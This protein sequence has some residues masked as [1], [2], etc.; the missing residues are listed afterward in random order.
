MMVK[1]KHKA[2]IEKGGFLYW[3]DFFK[4]RRGNPW[5]VRPSRIMMDNYQI[6]YMSKKNAFTQE[7]EYGEVFFDAEY[8]AAWLKHTFEG[9]EFLAFQ[10][11]SNINARDKFVEF[12]AINDIVVSGKNPRHSLYIKFKEYVYNDH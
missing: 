1:D 5:T 11:T 8:I 6:F 3:E 7:I 10:K 4:D 2:I 12:E 9:I